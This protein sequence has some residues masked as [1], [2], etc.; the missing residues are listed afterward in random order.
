MSVDYGR[1]RRSGLWFGLL[2]VGL[3]MFGTCVYASDPLNVRP[4]VLSR[5]AVLPGDQLI[6][7]CPVSKDFATPLTLSEAVDVALCNHPQIKQAWASIKVQA[8]ALGEAKAAYLPT[9]NG[10]LSR[11]YDRSV[12]SDNN[13]SSTTT[14]TNTGYASLTY[15]LLDFGG[16]SANRDAANQ[17]LIAALSS[18]DFALQ[19][20][21]GGVVQA[22]FDALSAKAYYEAKNQEEQL[23]QKTV[24]MAEQRVVKGVN[25][26]SE[27]L[28][29]KTTYARTALEKNR[30]FGA[31][32]KAMTVLTYALGLSSETEIIFPEQLTEDKDQ[33]V[34]DLASLM[35]EVQKNH[36]AIVSSRA[37]LES[38]KNKVTVVK[39]EGLPN[40][41]VSFSYYQ[42]GRPNQPVSTTRTAETTG[43]LTLNLPLF[44]GFA[45]NYKVYGAQAQVEQKEAELVDTTYQIQMELAKAHADALSALSNLRSSED[46][47]KVSNEALTISQVRYKKGAADIFEILNAQSTVV[48]AEQE[49][50][51]AL[52]EWR[53]AKFRLL[54]NAGMVN[55]MVLRN[56]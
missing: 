16:R 31:Y 17:A 8:G 12:L 46:L 9:I 33:A 41:D 6:F 22:Y 55:R 32:K 36:P 23:N 37:Q 25:S 13:E 43:Y 34:Q 27:G 38:V 48:N 56:Q 42:N 19:R 52:A 10:T 20:T 47:L 40:L 3:A 45:K 53:S 2:G 35:S 54:A 26:R 1:I 14:Y 21:I 18:H 39:S 44:D 29:T 15:R 24:D 7:V 49:R 4:D 50:I 11:V 51:R 30:A 5:G 28:Q